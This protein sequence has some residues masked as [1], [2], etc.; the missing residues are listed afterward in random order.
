MDLPSASE[1][2]GGS[3]NSNPKYKINLRTRDAIS[4]TKAQH[5]KGGGLWVFLRKK[6]SGDL[7][8]ICSVG[9]ACILIQTVQSLKDIFILCRTIQETCTLI[10]Y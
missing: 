9:L 2:A 6:S 4:L 1:Y 8:T 7:Q 10:R 5:S 3:S